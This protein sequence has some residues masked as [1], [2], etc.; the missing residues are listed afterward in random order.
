[1]GFSNSV[2]GGI[3]LVRP[4]IRSPNYVAASTG[5]T[6]NA[7]GTAEFNNV[8]VRGNLIVGP[9]GTQTW[10]VSG[11]SIPAALVTFYAGV[12]IG[13]VILQFTS[14]SPDRYTYMLAVTATVGT[15]V[16]WAMGQVNNGTVVEH[17][18]YT[19]DSSS[20]INRPKYRGAAAGSSETYTAQGVAIG[21]GGTI[22]F[23]DW[24]LT[25]DGGVSM[26]RGVRG[27]DTQ[28]ANSAAV[29]AETVL[30]S[31]TVP[32]LAGRAYRVT[33]GGRVAA[34]NASG[35]TR[36][37]IRKTNAAGT[38]WGDYGVVAGSL[39]AGDAQPMQGSTVL[40]RSAGTDLNGVTTCLTLQNLAGG[41]NTSNIVSAAVAPS[42]F[43]I[44][45]IGPA[46]A[47]PSAVAV[48]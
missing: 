12:T 25:C 47:Y 18:S 23:N 22:G 21:S 10:V 15:D 36:V 35:R 7:D 37:R 5:W 28:T 27:N 20:V 26:P 34:S 43:D 48:S 13:S 31:F 45:D 2:V 41:A 40:V 9:T 44:V 42:I 3:T 24:D 11:S 29:T 38:I 14:Q 30:M 17:Y 32:Y 4:A 39:T 19:T 33:V 46:S 1:M 16:F 6:I 8:T